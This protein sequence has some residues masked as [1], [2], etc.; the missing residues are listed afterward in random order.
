[1]QWGALAVKRVSSQREAV[2]LPVSA[3]LVVWTQPLLKE[4]CWWHSTAPC[5]N[6]LPVDTECFSMVVWPTISKNRSPWCIG[7]AYYT[8]T[9]STK[10]QEREVDTDEQKRQLFFLRWQKWV[11]GGGIEII[12]PWGESIS[13]NQVTYNSTMSP[14]TE[15][16]PEVIDQCTLPIEGLRYHTRKW[17]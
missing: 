5:S 11:N 6:T 2:H 15:H 17:Q 7:L 4:G 14:I 1:M 8:R 12:I 3:S 10:S 13:G 9:Q 16:R